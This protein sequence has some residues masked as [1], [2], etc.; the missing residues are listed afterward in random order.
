MKRKPDPT[1]QPPD[2]D[3]VTEGYSPPPT[4]KFR[5]GVGIVNADP[6]RIGLFRR[7]MAWL[8]PP[9]EPIGI[10]RPSRRPD[11]TKPA[12]PN[13]VEPLIE[14][15]VGTPPDHPRPILSRADS[16]LSKPST[17]RPTHPPGA[18]AGTRR[19]TDA[20]IRELQ[21]KGDAMWG[22]MAVTG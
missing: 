12:G 2:Y 7:F 4:G 9:I 6:P 17:P 11:P 8:N 16:V 3:L 10:R 1:I 18:Q 14:P 19:I 20:E 15:G 21:R 5:P 22:G 13:N